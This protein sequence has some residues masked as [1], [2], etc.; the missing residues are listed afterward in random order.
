[1]VW[2]GAE[3]GLEESY[4]SCVEALGELLSYCPILHGCVGVGRY[5]RVAMKRCAENG[6]RPSEKFSDGL[7]CFVV[8]SGFCTMDALSR[9]GRARLFRF[10]LFSFGM[11]QVVDL[12]DGINQFA[13]AATG[14]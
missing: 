7:F 3:S 13:V 4:C 8:R 2:G 9:Y 6:V 12:G 14:F 1:M 10:C 11:F 5:C